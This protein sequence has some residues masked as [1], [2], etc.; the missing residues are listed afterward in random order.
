[1]QYGIN[2]INVG[3]VGEPAMVQCFARAAERAGWDGVFVWD[4][5]WMWNHL[6]W[7]P[8][9][10]LTAAA[11][12]TERVCLGTN[13]T[14]V[15][16]RRPHVLAAQVATL[17]RLSGGRVILGVGLGGDADELAS[18][19]EETDVRRRAE[20]LDA[21]LDV[22]RGEWNGPIWV[23]GDAPAARRRAV[24]HDGWTVGTVGDPSGTVIRS[25]DQLR[26]EVA[27]LDGA[28]IDVVVEGLSSADD[29]A[30]VQA[31]EAAGATWWL[32]GIWGLRGPVD[33]LLARVEAGP[34][35]P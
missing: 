25:P 28:V 20:L 11:C 34:P 5:V 31:F 17:D 12:V 21:G 33:E 15:P 18:L 16:R 22:I 30:H 9:V 1:M 2:L 27:S 23:G 19:G 24:R 26:T 8:W 29:H 32:E 7:D 13:V 3:E 10:L 35:R 4:H 6:A 14:P